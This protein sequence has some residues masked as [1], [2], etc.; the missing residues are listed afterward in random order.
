[1]KGLLVF[2]L[3]GGA[4]GFRGYR[5]EAYSPFGCN[6]GAGKTAF[7][8]TNNIGWQANTAGARWNSGAAR[9]RFIQGGSDFSVEA[10]NAG[11]VPWAG[12]THD[13]GNYDTWNR[14]S[15][16]TV[17][18]INSY[19]GPPNAIEDVLTHEFGHVAGLDDI[20]AASP[21]CIGGN[22]YYSAVMHYSMDRVLGPCAIFDPQTDDINGVNSIY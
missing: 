10:L 6:W 9:L 2:A 18:T 20:N 22:F 1:M 11:S 4:L 19:Y 17:V 14:C 3:L 12:R 7:Y 8:F 16:G 21:G 15:V 5:A 13:P